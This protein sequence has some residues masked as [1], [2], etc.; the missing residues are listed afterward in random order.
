MK[1]IKSKKVVGAI[2]IAAAMLSV[3]SVGFASWVISGGDSE[4]LNTLGVQVASVQNEQISISTPT[5]TN[6]CG[7]AK[8]ENKSDK[9]LVDNTTT[10]TTA[11]IVFGPNSSDTT[12]LIQAGYTGDGD[13]ND[14]EHL[15]VQFQFTLSSESLSTRLKEIFITPTYPTVLTSLATSGYIK[16]PSETSKNRITLFTAS[17]TDYSADQTPTV[18][19][20][21]FSVKLSAINNNSITVTVTANWSWGSAF[22]NVNPASNDSDQSAVDSAVAGINA[23]DSAIT[24][25]TDT[26]VSFLIEATSN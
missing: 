17:S 3:G 22:N 9:T 6:V 15:S 26:N 2:V 19:G 10:P 14:V 25:A 21:D 11:Y 4:T 1:H 16:N 20:G 5:Y 7:K 24:E 23:I 13:L 18:T 12:G 8:A